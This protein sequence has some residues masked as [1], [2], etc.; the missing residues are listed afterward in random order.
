MFMVERIAA[1]PGEKVDRLRVAGELTV[2]HGGELKETLCEAL[3]R[4]GQIEVDLSGVTAIDLAGLQLLCAAHASAA[5]R[6]KSFVLAVPPGRVVERAMTEAGFSR[7]IG[8]SRGDSP[9]CCWVLRPA[10]QDG[11]FPAGSQLTE[12]EAERECGC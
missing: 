2:I 10:T 1:G 3:D 8:C 4:M 9:S 5:S 7:H 12:P 6:G 11:V